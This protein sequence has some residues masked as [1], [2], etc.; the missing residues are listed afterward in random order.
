MRVLW[1]N[2]VRVSKVKQRRKQRMQTGI[3]LT[4]RDIYYTVEWYH[5]EHHSLDKAGKFTAHCRATELAWGQDNA[6]DTHETYKEACQSCI[7]SIDRY[8]DR[9]L[10]S[11]LDSECISLES[12]SKRFTSELYATDVN[13][14]NSYIKLLKVQDAQSM[15]ALQRFL[16]T[17]FRG[18]NNTYKGKI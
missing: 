15:E 3:Q 4:H 9:Y 18:L 5:P 7:E 1:V 16:N 11:Y 2:L 6:I 17:L 13:L 10:D 12:A 8:L 14:H